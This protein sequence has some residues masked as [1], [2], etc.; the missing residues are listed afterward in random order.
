MADN[1]EKPSS[2]AKLRDLIK[3]INDITGL[4]RNQRDMLRQRGVNLPT[5]SI[6]NLRALKKRLDV[7]QKTISDSQQELRSLRALA[8]TTALINS[9]QK[10]DEVLNQVMDTVIALTGAERGYIMLRNADTQELEFR[11]ARGMEQST[12]DGSKGMIVS[13]TIVNT[14]ADTGE[15]VLTDNASTD[16]RYDSQESIVGFQLRSILAVPM[17]VR[18]KVLGVVYCDNR[19]LQGLFQ[20]SELNVLTAFANQAAVA[21]ENA[22]LFESTQTR[23]QEITELRDRMMNL[24]SSIASGVLTINQDKQVLVCN[25]TMEKIAQINDVIGKSLSEAL[26]NMPDTFHQII[27][28]VQSTGSQVTRE[29]VLD[30]AGKMRNWT[31]IASPLRGDDGT[32]GVAMV[33]DDM[34][35]H[36]QSEAQ[37]VEVRRYLPEALVRNMSTLDITNIETQEREITAMFADVRGFTSFSEN[38]E[39]EDLMRVINKYLSIASD[40]IGLFEGIVDKYMGDAVTGLW[41]TQLNP[42]FDHPNRAVQAAMQLVLDLH[43]MH[44]VLPEDE[45]LFYGIGIHTGEAV[46]GN[47]GSK[48]RKEFSA[49]GNATDVCK[50]LQEQAGASEVIISQATF[51]CVSDIWECER[52]EDVV[53]SKKGYEDIVFYRVIKRKKGTSTA[54]IDDELLAL[55]AADEDD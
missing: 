1:Q 12:L 27:T 34:T 40:S 52:R 33:I 50:Y 36:K 22:R 48:G 18:D 37:L 41:N 2:S 17:K 5:G 54:L 44:E 6:D 19:F 29:I 3:Q 55:L 32:K 49:L 31:V 9:A 21:L 20:Q 26:P 53:R 7:L 38:L 42:Q 13:K 51:E 23:L 14:V 43:A 28:D 15:P 39:P 11:V 10:T 35:E 8:E 25:T 47:V 24:F 45:R 4:L 46:L 30:V 16:S